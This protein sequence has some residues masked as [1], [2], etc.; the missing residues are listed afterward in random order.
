LLFENAIFSGENMGDGS[1]EKKNSTTLFLCAMTSQRGLC[2][3][4]PDG[5]FGENSENS[6][7]VL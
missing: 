5:F 4:G 3:R 1:R 7:T 6:I 2:I